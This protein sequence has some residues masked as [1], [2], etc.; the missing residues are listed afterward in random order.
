[1]S[2]L[3]VVRHGSVDARLVSL[4]SPGDRER[5]A[6]FGGDTER[7][8]RFLAGRAA[9]RSA[10]ARMGEPGIVVQAGCPECGL[11]HGRPTAGLDGA[12]RS[13]YLALTHCGGVAI[14]VASRRP[15]GIDAEPVSTS[16]ERRAAIDELAPGRGDAVQRWTAIE[17]VLKADGRGLRL[18]PD[19]VRLGMP[20]FGMPRFG[21]PG[22]A[23]RSARLDGRRYGLRTMRLGGCIV[24]V[25][26]ERANSADRAI[27]GP[28]DS[29]GNAV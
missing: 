11:S 22:I 16:S 10:A 28:Q 5:F 15:V 13:L 8:G 21:M 26:T 29:A 12:S 4:L 6:S 1:M 3:A 17:A 20:R 18:P 19:A 9:L 27:A 25:A 7:E 23:R 24:T 14:A 2:Q